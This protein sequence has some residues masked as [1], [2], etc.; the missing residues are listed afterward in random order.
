MNDHVRANNYRQRL[1]LI[2][3]AANDLHQQ[4]VRGGQQ[5]KR[6]SLAAIHAPPFKDRLRRLSNPKAFFTS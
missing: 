4:N 2:Q 6:V 1:R 3:Q 5:D